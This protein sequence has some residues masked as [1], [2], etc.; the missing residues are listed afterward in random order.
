[1]G[2]RH[3][4]A[5]VVLVGWLNAP[6]GATV[7]IFFIDVEGGQATLIVTPRQSML[8]D[9]G[10]GRTSRDPDR[11]VAAALAAGVKRIDY[12]VVTHFHADHVGGVSE[13]ASRIPITTFV[14]YGQPMGTPYGPDGMS[15][16]GFATYEPARRNGFH[17]TPQPGDRLPLE[18][19]D[20]TVVSAGGSLLSAPLPLGG[21]V[22]DGCAPQD[23]AGDETENFRSLGIVLRY[24]A[25]TFVDLGDLSGDTLLK[26]V[27]PRNLLGR[28]SAYL[29]AHHG[30]YDSNAPVIYTALRPQVAILNNGPLKGGD[31]TTLRTVRGQSAIDL[32]QLHT[33]RHIGAHNA[34][35][36]FIANVDDDSST[37]YWLR[38]RAHED[39]SFTIVNN[40]N[41]F[42][43]TYAGR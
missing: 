12:L 6:V 9:A 21:E 3:L 8:I 33:A 4:A 40:R 42:S 16:R 11:I 5:V 26:L 17:L 25:F 14:D 23:H 36:D 38:L 10:Y 29:I 28:A 41:G 35:T 31:P 32:W 30:S 22:T 19:V 7:E 34:P 20:V 43:K 13:L 2:T 1:M 18:G 24:G 37:V 39:G 27:C 15:V